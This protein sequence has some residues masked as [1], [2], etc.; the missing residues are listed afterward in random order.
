MN[1]QNS[2]FTPSRR[3]LVKGAAWSVPVVAMASPAMAVVCSPNNTSPECNPVTPPEFVPGSACKF[4]GGSCA[5]YKHAYRAA[6]CS[7]NST[8]EPIVVH[9]AGVRVNNIPHDYNPSQVTIQPNQTTCFYIIADET[10]NSANGELAFDYWYNYVNEYGNTVRVPEEGVLT[11]RTGNNALP[12]CDDCSDVW[13]VDGAAPAAAQQE[14]SP[15]AP[16]AEQPAQETI[17][18]EEPITEVQGGESAPEAV[19]SDTAGTRESADTSVSSG[20]ADDANQT[21]AP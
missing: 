14:D 9:I 1:A 4:P 7:T 13:G 5:G 21:T 19:G 10:G 17:T 3:T 12:P 18:V 8:S 6:F 2:G 20:G 16:E 11:A 15:A